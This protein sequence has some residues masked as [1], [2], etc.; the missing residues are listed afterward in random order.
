MKNTSFLVVNF[1][2]AA[3]FMIFCVCVWKK[4][5]SVLSIPDKVVYIQAGWLCQ[6]VWNHGYIQNAPNIVKK[7]SIFNLKFAKEA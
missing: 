3:N 2:E 6:N 4:V 1:R 7:E 5:K